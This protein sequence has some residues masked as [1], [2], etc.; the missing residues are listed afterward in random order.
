[1]MGWFCRGSNFCVSL[2]FVLGIAMKI[3]LV[4]VGKT[5]KRY[6]VEAFDEY[7]KRL[8]RYVRFDVRVLPDLRN[9]KSMPMEQQMQKEGVSRLAAVAEAQEVVLLDEHGSMPTSRELAAS[10]ERRMVHGQRDLAFVIGGPYGFS[11]DVRQ[12]ANGQ[13]SLSKLTF[14]HQ[15]VRVIFVEQL[16]RAFTIIEGEPYHHE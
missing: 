3:T 5:E 10:I 14:S 16:Y 12:R 15:M 8:S 4:M 7:V 1:M 6:L 11:S 9:T 13:L 2:C